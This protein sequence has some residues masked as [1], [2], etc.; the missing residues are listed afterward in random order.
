MKLSFLSAALLASAVSLCACKQQPP[1]A[2][3]EAAQPAPSTKEQRIEA[4]KKLALADSRGATKLDQIILAQ[5]R[6]VE[7]NPR[8][9]DQWITLGRS[10]IEKAR[11]TSDPGFY[12]HADACADVVLATEP[13]NKLALGLKSLVALSEH[14]FA[15]ARTIADRALAED[16]DESLARAARSDA[17]FELGEVDEAAKSAQRLMDAKPGLPSY[18]RVAY[19][20]W[21]HGRSSD[22]KRLALLAID[23]GRDGQDVEP[24]AW[25]LV[26]TATFFWHEG[27]YEGAEAG[28]DRALA[29]FPDY[30]PALV[31]KARAA[32]SRGDAARAAPLLARAAE[33]SPLVETSWLRLEV[34]EALGHA[35]AARAAR[36]KL[37]RDGKQTD[38]RT[39]SQFWST[40]G[41]RPDEALALA[42]D[43]MK[44]RPGIYTRDALAWALYRK[45]RFV[46]AKA[47]SDDA[48]KYGTKDA[49]LL[50]HAGAIRIALGEQPAGR[51]LV[52][53][54]LAKNPAFD[55]SGAREARALLASNDKPRTP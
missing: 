35:D 23:A 29:V 19:L 40:R 39:L 42:E 12:L 22:A 27:D 52:E 24:Y 8:K 2:P 49:R 53:E 14:R 25:Q 6:A 5:R 17:S 46:E 48:T 31:G 21:I 9:L 54:A 43:E 44:I 34:E 28:H 37:E 50:Y 16:P 32:L 55:R 36:E 26:Q 13:T 1:P 3:A 10:W 7:K 15:E 20:A 47:A 11:A 51:A 41:E 18:S 30:P 38:H 45:G 33:Q 4:S